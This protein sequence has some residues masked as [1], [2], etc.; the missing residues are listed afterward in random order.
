MYARDRVVNEFHCSHQCWGLG[1]LDTHTHT[2]TRTHAHT[3]KVEVLGLGHQMTHML[4]SSQSFEIVIISSCGFAISSRHNV[5]PSYYGTELAMV[6]Y[7]LHGPCSPD[8]EI[9]K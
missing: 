5:T 9:S 3:L 4:E 8:D 1:L 7:R 2:Y 6:S